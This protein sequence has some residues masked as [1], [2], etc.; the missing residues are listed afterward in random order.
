[1][2][3]LVLIILVVLLIVENDKKNKQ[4]TELYKEL[5]KV[6]KQSNP[7]S[8]QN[9]VKEITKKEEKQ[10]IQTTQTQKKEITHKNKQDI[11]NTLI[12]IVGS[13]LIILAAI[14]FLL[15]TWNFTNNLIKTITI[16]L[17]LLIFKGIEHIS[18]DKLKLPKTAKAFRYI[19]LAY[20]PIVLLSVSFFSLLGH[21]LSLYGEGR[22]I[23]L[24][25]T[26]IITTVVY[27]KDYK[28]EKDIVTEIASIIFSCIS[29]ISLVTIFSK[30]IS[31]IIT[32]LLLYS[33]LY[34]LLYLKN[35]N[36]YEKKIQKS[37]A[38]II[39]ISTQIIAIYNNL[40][41]II[42][43]KLYFI[44]NISNIL[45]FINLYILMTKIIKRKDI[46]NIIYPI[47]TI[48][49][50]FS[51]SLIFNSFQITKIYIIASCSL[52]YI[53]TITQKENLNEIT[54]ETLTAMTVL[55]ITSIFQNESHNF[56][57][58]AIETIFLSISY[59]K[60]QTKQEISYLIITFLEI[61]TL[62]II[63]NYNLNYALFGIISISLT[64]ISQLTKNINFQKSFR[65][66]GDI[67]IA[68]FTLTYHN[69][70]IIV[71]LLIS[72][73][74]SLTTYYITKEDIK[75]KILSYIYVYPLVLSII[76]LL[77]I[78]ETLLFIPIS[79]IICILIETFISKKD[80]DKDIILTKEIISII[81]LSIL[82]HSTQ[83]LMLLII[84]NL[85]YTSY[86]KKKNIK[87]NY[88]YPAL[89]S[90]LPYIITNNIYI[91]D[92]SIMH[93][94]SLWI[95]TTFIF[96][97]I[98]KDTNTYNIM[99]YIYT[100]THCI[101]FKEIIYAKLALLIIGTIIIYMKKNKDIYKIILYL[102]TFIL[103]KNIFSDLDIEKISIF[104]KGIYLIYLT[105]ITRTILK[106]QIPDYKSLIYIGY[107]IINLF[108]LTNY[109]SEYDGLLFVAL[110]T[111]IVIISY[112][113]KYGPEFITCLTFILIN[114]LLLTRN[115]WLNIPWWIYILTIGGALIAFAT[116]NELKQTKIT[117]NEKI[118]KLKRH[119]DL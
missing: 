41:N 107:I 69:H 118:I 42:N 80:I 72:Y 54:F 114:T 76:K 67:S 13:V 51:A 88:L 6:K 112:E 102:L 62:F 70:L 14:A 85:I 110:L 40:D 28:K 50:F 92:Y 84:T 63:I 4:I 49:T 59:K 65:H 111:I 33:I 103:F 109:N 87:E 117:N 17:M 97:T 57:I 27:Y 43:S 89:L 1:M 35:I 25:I 58:P 75:Y 8:N 115:F 53:Y 12:L 23:Y 48:Y 3:T 100:M 96:I 108:T 73:I 99:F 86:I 18:K 22:N 30:N 101:I 95:I 21:Y 2:F 64:L 91:Y 5:C 16:S 90:F 34:S 94:I 32:S 36:I 39:A 31:I 98:K 45:F 11:S 119:L 38:R 9:R 61:T 79:T 26:T 71:L 46:F 77:N 20:F 82:T 68:L 37:S 10:I 44:D 60:I 105:L 15:T 52:L 81:T 74:I 83:N 7:Q 19:S 24:T 106:K 78:K 93:A 104:S 116:N 113:R 55:F 56:I 47:L 29:I 66:V